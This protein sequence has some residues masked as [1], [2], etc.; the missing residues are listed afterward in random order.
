[1]IGILHW[2]VEIGRV[3][4]LLEVSFLSS[5]LVLPRVVHLQVVYIVFGYI[6]QVPKRKLYFDPRKPIIFEYRFQK[7]DW[8]DFYPCHVSSSGIVP[9]VVSV[10]KT[11]GQH[12]LTYWYWHI[13]GYRFTS[14]GVEIFPIKLLESILGYIIGFL[15]SKYSLRLGTCLRYPNTLYTACRCPTRSNASWDEIKYTSRSM[16]TLPILTAQHRI[17]I[18]S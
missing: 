14:V 3:D 13:Q 1:M 17:P 6:K 15:G 5:Q 7:F 10:Y 12:K 16:S 8:E 2:S 18:K 4:I 9:L 11:V